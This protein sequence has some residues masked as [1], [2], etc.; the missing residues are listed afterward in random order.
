[1]LIWRK[2]TNEYDQIRFTSNL[3]LYMTIKYDKQSYSRN[4]RIAGP[5]GALRGER[6][7]V[8]RKGNNP[9]GKKI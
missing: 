2:W 9:M 3:S 6:Q 8:G 1:M 4:T 5:R 7:E